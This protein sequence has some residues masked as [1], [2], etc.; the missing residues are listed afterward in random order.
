LSYAFLPF[1][2][3]STTLFRA[4]FARLAEKAKGEAFALLPRNED[5]FLD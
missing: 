5:E 3:L 1:L 2:Q 4:T